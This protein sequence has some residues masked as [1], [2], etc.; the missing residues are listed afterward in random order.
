MLLK[1]DLTLDQAVEVSKNIVLTQSQ[2]SSLQGM[3]HVCLYN[4]SNNNYQYESRDKSTKYNKYWE[5]SHDAICHK[6]KRRNHYRMGLGLGWIKKYKILLDR[7]CVLMF[8]DTYAARFQTL[9][10]MMYRLYDKFEK[11]DYIIRI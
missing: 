1:S 4:K 10:A 7:N 3:S 6:C 5:G 8:K 9:F 2:A 11:N